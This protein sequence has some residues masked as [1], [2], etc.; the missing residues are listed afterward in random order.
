MRMQLL[1]CAT[2]TVAGAS[3]PN[4]GIDDLAL[5]LVRMATRLG[6]H[7]VG[8]SP[9]TSF[10]IAG[11]ERSYKQQY[12]NLYWL[13]LAALRARVL[14][15]AKRRWSTLGEERPE[16]V[17]RVL[18]V[19]TR[20]LCYIVG[21]VYVDMALKPN[22]L[23]DLA[24]EHWLAPLPPRA[25]FCADNDEVMLEDESGRVRLIGEVIQRGAGT[26]VTGTIMAVMGAENDDGDFQV[27]DI[28]YAGLPPQPKLPP[29]APAPIASSSHQDDVEMKASVA[30]KDEGEWIALVSGLEMGGSSDAA[31]LRVQL[32]AEWLIGELGDDEDQQEAVKVTRLI[33]AG[34][35]LLRP[36][37]SVDDAKKPVRRPLL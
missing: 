34:N 18:D 29:P 6:S 8:A 36:E 25:K 24:R 13:R 22:V 32:F 21:T 4:A 15:E 7:D 12:A 10:V 1:R 33:L 35:S 2:R 16:A 37:L 28:C 9:D 11:A 3:R 27:V 14:A 19:Q 23:A 31:D 17:G 30:A 5:S 26:Y 20:Q